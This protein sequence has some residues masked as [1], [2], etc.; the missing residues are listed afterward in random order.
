V[1]STKTRILIVEDHLLVRDALAQ[2][3]SAARGLE[4]VGT[5]ATIREARAVWERTRPDLLLVDLGLRRWER[6]R[7]DPDPAADAV[8]SACADGHW[9][10]R[11]I[12]IARGA[13][14]RE[15]EIFRRVVVG[16][17]SREISA[18]LSICVRT[19]G[20]HRARINRKRAVT[21]GMTIAA[22]AN[23]NDSGSH[24]DCGTGQ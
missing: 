10:P 11:H 8:K 22:N 19:V 9:I 12:V 4:I 15:R 14:G 16:S 21:H 1:N 17:S 5:A 2:M 3:L 7:V 18:S 6:N 24:R 13:G 20:T 23:S